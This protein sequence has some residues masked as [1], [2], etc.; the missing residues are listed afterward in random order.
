[1]IIIVPVFSN[2]ILNTFIFVHVRAFTRRVEPHALGTVINVNSNNQ[3]LRISRREIALLKQMIFLFLTFII[4]WSP[5]YFTLII[6]QFIYVDQIVYECMVLVCEI[7]LLSL[8]INLF[9]CN[10]K[11]RQYLFNKIRFCFVY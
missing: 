8:I 10:Q 9:L 11:L 3:Q 7:S 6:N 1:M 5:M 2:I 4:G